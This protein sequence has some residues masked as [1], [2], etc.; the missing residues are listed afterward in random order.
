MLEKISYEEGLPIKVQVMNVQEYPW[1][2][3]K[4]IQ[5]LYVLEGEIELKMTYVRYR[6]TENKMHFIHSDDV[7]GLIGIT[8]NN[9]VVVLSLNMEY[10]SETFPNLDT[11]VFSIKATEDVASYKRQ[12]SLK[13][14]IFSIISELYGPSKNYKKKIKTLSLSLIKALYKDFRSFNISR[15]DKT[16]E[17]T[18]SHDAF[19]IDRISRIVSYVYQ[20]YPYK[21][22]LTAL[23]EKE[24]INTYYLS[25]LFHSYV[26]E[27]FRNFVSMVRVEMSE[28]Q[29]LTSNSSISQISQNVGFSNARYYIDNFKDWFG[30]HPKEYRQLY[31]GK[32]I[33]KAAAQVTYL[34]LDSINKVIESDMELPIF[35]N[36]SKGITLSVDFTCEPASLLG[37]KLLTS[38]PAWSDY[39][40]NSAMTRQEIARFYQKFPP[41]KEGILFLQEYFCNIHKPLP[42]LP[43]TD[44]LPDQTGIYAFN[45]LK[46]PL[47][48][49]L[50]WI[51][52]LYHEVACMSPQCLITRKEGRCRIILFNDS[53]C[54]E[55]NYTFNFCPE[56]SSYKVVSH[57]MNRHRSF[58]YYWE[59]LN[60][61]PD[62][63]ESDRLSI[64]QATQPEICFTIISGGPGSTYEATLRPM[65]LAFIDCA[66][67]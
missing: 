44:H 67:I 47:H 54:E 52:L 45:G 17:H 59:Q 9:L 14:H 34:P 7:H 23:A 33:G 30:C 38:V 48:Y 5:I 43:F 21:L 3:H 29:L 61:L 51:K 64:N 27:S 6:L 62:L 2:M 19:Q 55:S 4:D 42:A 18:V 11:Q 16:F 41:I 31:A 36:V 60:F 39:L 35:S 25:H 22:S 37:P 56:N 28:T 1:H 20:N 12:L 15:E 24:N 40:A 46:K 57:S 26:K 13:T 63:P 65:E 8:K 66:P 53:D 49:I 50:Q 10:F 32:V 58:D